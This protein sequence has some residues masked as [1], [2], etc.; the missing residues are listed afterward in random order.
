MSL[1]APPL[2]SP[3]LERAAAARL[4]WSPKEMDDAVAQRLAARLA[5][6]R[7][8]AG[9]GGGADALADWPVLEREQ[10]GAGDP[11]RWADPRIPRALLRSA[12][13][14]GRSGRPL[15][16][17][18][19]PSNVV[20]EEVFVRRQLRAFGWTPDWPAIVIRSDGPRDPAGPVFEADPTRRRT[21]RVAASRLDD[22]AARA[23]VAHGA[24]AGVQLLA[25]YPS[26][27]LE[28]ARRIESL[29]LSLDGWPLRV[30]QVS[31]EALTE[32]AEARLR[33]V[34]GVPVADHYGQTERALAIQSCPH[35]ARHLVR[36]YGVGE[37]IDGAWVGTPLF[38]RS[39]V[40]VRYATGDLAGPAPSGARIDPP[41]CPCGWPFPRVG[42]VAGRSDDVVVTTDGR[43]I[44]RIGPAFGGIPGLAQVQIEQAAVGSLL[45]RALGTD[46][47]I[48]ALPAA[49]Q[50]LLL[51]PETTIELRQEAPVLEANG[52][53]R[54]VR[55]RLQLE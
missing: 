17:L 18:R 27:L 10:L 47:A 7:R 39:P 28:L 4:R 51:D 8:V 48:A 32:A 46:P 40:L 9:Y 30:I 43:R 1:R 5:L 12:S 31:S 25:G 19:D 6:A 11:G 2:L 16:V 20:L 53:I 44:G 45:V 42:R 23:L 26:A 54:V 55:S 35:G 3:A 13:T 41:G 52:R 22:R 38:G 21:V 49:L 37:L 14:S 24:A 50:A 15:T 33:A 29:E 34:F 36:D